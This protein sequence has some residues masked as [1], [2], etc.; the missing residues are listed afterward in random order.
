MKALLCIGILSG[1]ANCASPEEHFEIDYNS[2][3]PQIPFEVEY[4]DY[5]K[6]VY[7]VAS[8]EKRADSVTLT[9]PVNAELS[10]KV[11]YDAVNKAFDSPGVTRI[12]I[13]RMEGIK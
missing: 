8:C 5:G 12:Q 4:S 11:V 7:V 6:T 3:L 13:C 2:K 9:L 10:A 1:L